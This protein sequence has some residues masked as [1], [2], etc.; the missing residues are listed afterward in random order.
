[1]F[2]GLVTLVSIY[3]TIGLGVKIAQDDSGEVS[4]KVIELI[5]N[6]AAWPKEVYDKFK[7]D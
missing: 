6:S 5:K 4:E 1:M 3:F 7:K 2:T